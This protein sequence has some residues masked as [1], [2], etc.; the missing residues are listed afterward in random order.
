MTEPESVKE[1]VAAL[2]RGILRREP[3]AAGLAAYSEQIITGSMSISAALESFLASEEYKRL[4]YPITTGEGL[5]TYRAPGARHEKRYQIIDHNTDK[6]GNVIKDYMKTA[7][8]VSFD[9]FCPEFEKF[10]SS[11]DHPVILHRKLWEFAFITHHLAAKG[12]LRNNAKGV[13]FGVG[14]EPLPSLFASLGCKV[15]AT[16]API[17]VVNKGWSETKQHSESRESLFFPTIVS[18]GQFE[19]NV[20]FSAVDMNAIDESLGEFD[21]CWSACCFEHLGTLER[22]LHFVEASVEKL[23]K[24]GGVACHTS[25]LNLSSN[26]ETIEA[27]ETVLYR[28]EDVR[29][30]VNRLRRRGHICELLPFNLGASFVDHLVDVPGNNG[31]VHL[32]LKLGRFVTTSFGIVVTR[33]T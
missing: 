29:R 11:I 17:E 5:V 4:R 10:C 19:R 30:F 32:R 28:Q 1:L 21:F 22:G 25:E 20:T 27:G 13:G 12:A 2:Y 7:N 26:T 9:F 8:C 31:D 6:R 23:L 18:E 16:D 3:D 14:R 24:V 33:G 15:L